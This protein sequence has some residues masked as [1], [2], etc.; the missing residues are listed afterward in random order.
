M[1][2]ICISFFWRVGGFVM[3][4]DETQNMF[5]FVVFDTGIRFTTTETQNERE[6]LIDPDL[7]ILLL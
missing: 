7:I 6:E 3:A 1:K 2:Q 5:L 4:T